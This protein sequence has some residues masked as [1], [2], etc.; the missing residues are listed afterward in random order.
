MAT[1]TQH[2][3]SAGITVVGDG[4]LDAAAEQVCRFLSLDVDARG[5]PDVAERDPFIAEAQAQLPGLRPCG[6]HS[7][8]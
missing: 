6:F 8:Y 5:W 2:N 7:P 4:D 1:V 3:A